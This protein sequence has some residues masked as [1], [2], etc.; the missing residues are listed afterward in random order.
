MITSAFASLTRGLS[1]LAYVLVDQK[2]LPQTHPAKN[3]QDI[4]RIHPV[5][6]RA[7]HISTNHVDCM[8][9]AGSNKSPQK[10]TKFFLRQEG[11]EPP[12]RRWQRRILPLN[13]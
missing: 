13:H 6:A 11:I 7:S 9:V 1:L 10:I 8:Y 2:V 3:L 4:D 5:L 12:A